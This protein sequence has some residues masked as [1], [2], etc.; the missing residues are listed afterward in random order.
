[1]GWNQVG[2]LALVVAYSLWMLVGGLCGQSPFTAE[3]GRHP[4][5]A[6]ARGALG[7]FDA[8]YKGLVVII[9]GGVIASSLVFQGLNALY[10]FSRRKQIE[11][12]VRET[13]PW[14]LNLQSLMAAG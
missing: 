3:I 14:V 9:Y 8:L 12:Y 2:L 1:L 7:Q 5:L 4:E 11:A 13:P 10:Y 6:D